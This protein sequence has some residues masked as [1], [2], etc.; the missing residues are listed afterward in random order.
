MNST[1]FGVIHTP[2]ILNVAVLEW[3]AENAEEY[4]HAVQNMMAYERECPIFTHMPQVA[5]SFIKK[6]GPQREHSLDHDTS[7]DFESN[8]QVVQK[9]KRIK[10]E[11][12]DIVPQRSSNVSGSKKTP[13]KPENKNVDFDKSGCSKNVLFTP[14]DDICTYK[15]RPNKNGDK[16]SVTISGNKQPVEALFNSTPLLNQPRSEVATSL[17]NRF[18]TDGYICL[19]GLLPRDEV[20]A[21]QRHMEDS[22]SDMG[23]IDRK[24]GETTEKGNYWCDFLLKL[25]D[26]ILYFY[27]IFAS[28]CLT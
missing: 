4:P 6:R 5:Q 28:V 21:A 3:L 8:E 16:F 10:K 24:T 19:R 12:T 27:D 14:P 9:N 1:P 17:W 20:E 25:S 15:V 22:L 13:I 18:K 2:D 23:Y 11:S 26:K 7:D